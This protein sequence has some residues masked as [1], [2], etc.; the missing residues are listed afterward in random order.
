MNAGT[1]HDEALIDATLNATAETISDMVTSALHNGHAL[2]DLAVVVQRAFDGRVRMGCA[3]RIDVARQ[4]GGDPRL[5]ADKR[6]AVSEACQTT[7]PDQLPIVL[8]VETEGYVAVGVRQ[9]RGEVG[10]LS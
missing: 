7:P 4:F 10:A 2:G 1:T 3:R 8:L 5:A 9:G 6:K